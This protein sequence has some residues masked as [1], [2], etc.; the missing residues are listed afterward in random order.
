MLLENK[1]YKLWKTRFPQNFFVFLQTSA[2]IIKDSF[3]SKT[4][5]WLLYFYLMSQLFT[6]ELR[7]AR[8]L[9]FFSTKTETLLVALH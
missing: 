6:A 3:L 1:K 7:P 5:P 8:I 9:N 4:H 2:L